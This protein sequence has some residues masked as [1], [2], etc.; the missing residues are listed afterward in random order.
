MR[1]NYFFPVT[2]NDKEARFLEGLEQN[3][4]AKMMIFYYP[5]IPMSVI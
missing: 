3:G 5:I 2:T 4:P 1:D